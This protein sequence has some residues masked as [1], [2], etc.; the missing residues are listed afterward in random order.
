MMENAG[1]ENDGPNRLFARS[2]RFSIPAVWSSFPVLEFSSSRLESPVYVSAFDAPLLTGATWPPAEDGDGPST[3][4]VYDPDFVNDESPPS[5]CLT[6]SLLSLSLSLSIS[7]S[8][9][10]YLCMREIL[11]TLVTWTL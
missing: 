7:L 1:L 6:P 11:G 10:V 5:L 9:C 4:T 2:C 8:L 3:K